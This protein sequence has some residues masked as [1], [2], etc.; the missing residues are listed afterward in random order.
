VF[1]SLKT[2]IRVTP[3]FLHT[4]LFSCPSSIRSS[5]K[6]FYLSGGNHMAL[7]IGTIVSYGGQDTEVNREQLRKEGWLICDGQK[8][9]IQEYGKLFSTIGRA[10]GGEPHTFCL[11]DLRGQFLRGVD[12]TKK[13][14]TDAA[15]RE[16]L[17][18]GGNKGAEVG[19]RQRS[20]SE[21][22][23]RTKMAAYAGEWDKP[24]SLSSDHHEDKREKSDKWSQASYTG[25][26]LNQVPCLIQ[27]QQK[28]TGDTRPTNV[29]VHFIIKFE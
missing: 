13:I 14:D 10:F 17:Q 24:H 1:V 23:F 28:A 19:S 3:A 15:D 6:S 21:F 20:V 7:P 18:T 27:F 25:G 11:P 8:V 22:T 9:S 5:F 4:I 16:P 2:L 12:N 26:N 29:S